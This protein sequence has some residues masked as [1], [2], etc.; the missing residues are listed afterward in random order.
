M[1]WEPKQSWALTRDHLPP[2]S[3]TDAEVDRGSKSPLALS[4]LETWKIEE[5]RKEQS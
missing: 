1:E 5:E 2:A 3:L 4:L